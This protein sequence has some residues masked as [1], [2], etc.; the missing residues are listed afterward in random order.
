MNPESSKKKILIVDDTP[1][2]IRMLAYMLKPNYSVSFATDGKKALKIAGAKNPPDLILLDIVMPGIDGYEVCR[3]LKS[4]KRTRNIPVILI[5]AVNEDA[6]E[7][8]GL[9]LGAADYIT[10]PFSMAIVKARVRTHLELKIH[11]ETLEHLSS[12]DGLTGIPNRQ[13]FDEY[14]DAEWRGAVRESSLLSLM[15]IDIDY[16]RNFNEKYLYMAGDDCLRRVAKAL[17]A[18]VRRSGDFVAR[19]GGEEFAAVLPGT[20]ASGARSVGENMRNNIES[21]N[22][23]NALSSVMN[24]VT[25]SVGTASISPSRNL[26]ANVLIRGADDSLYQA[27]KEGR[28][29]VKSLNLDI[30]V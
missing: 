29:R 6:D 3:R 22:I 24:C 5:S 25:V 23:P 4:E 28:N 30:F 1:E 10:K 19:Y 18:S 26:S 20:D 12:F 21:L 27:K 16:F 8:K 17:A 14:F 7:T 15:M 9:E 2:N 11:R 13:R